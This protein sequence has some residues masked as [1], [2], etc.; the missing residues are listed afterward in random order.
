MT[1]QIIWG[2]EVTS[3][4][5]TKYYRADL[6]DSDGKEYKGV[7]IFTSFK[8]YAKVM[9]G[10]EVEGKI[11]EK[12]YQGKPSYTLENLAPLQY[13]ASKAGG[14]STK[15]GE[16]IKQAQQRKT[17]SIS[18]FNS[19]NSAISLVTSQGYQPRPTGDAEIK[20]ALVYW[21]DWFLKEFEKWDNQPF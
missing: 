16:E 14:Y 13:G 17:E 10:S 21:R 5:G 11:S 19:V 4:K 2:E 15:K 9:P 18:Y 1:Y 20:E 8:D 6:K 12:D 3:S 7:A